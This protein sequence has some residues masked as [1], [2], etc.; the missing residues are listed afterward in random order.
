MRGAARS[1]AVPK[2]HV[3]RRSMTYLSE[4]VT[5]TEVHD[6][7]HRF[8]SYESLADVNGAVGPYALVGAENDQW[9]KL[10]AGIN[11]NLPIALACI[12]HVGLPSLNQ[13]TYPSGPGLYS[14]P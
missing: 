11:M 7:I 2:A 13:V 8:R 10:R 4:S 3:R 6:D 1:C 14:T 5:D 12:V 9:P